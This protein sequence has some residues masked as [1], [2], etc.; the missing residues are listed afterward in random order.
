[1]LGDLAAHLNATGLSVT[2]ARVTPAM[3]AELVALIEDGAISGKQAKDVLI[4]MAESG[5]APGAVVELRGMRLV[6]DADAIEAAVDAVLAADPDK[7]A[8]YRAG[9]A[10]L[11][12]WFV[13]QVMREMRGQGNPAVV[14]EVL[15][16]KLG[17]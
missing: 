9:K 12:G 2:D 7:V 17:A 1:M 8:Q 13:G 6:S 10:G 5:E 16:R 15:K 4:E 14:N 3:M 11:I